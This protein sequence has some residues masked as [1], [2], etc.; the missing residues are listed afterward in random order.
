M[1]GLRLRLSRELSSKSRELLT[2]G[3]PDARPILRLTMTYDLPRR[4]VVW[5]KPVEFFFLSEKI[6]PKTCSREFGDPIL[7]NIVKIPTACPERCVASCQYCQREENIYYLDKFPTSVE[8]CV[9]EAS[10]VNS[11]IGRQTRTGERPPVKDEIFY[12]RFRR[13]YYKGLLAT[14][15]NVACW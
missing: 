6:P 15:R 7:A 14:L 8:N 1:P 4:A 5:F 12:R 13:S 10:A 3:I 2:S 11:R 9:Y